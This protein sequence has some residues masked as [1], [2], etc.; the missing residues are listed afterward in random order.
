MLCNVKKLTYVEYA[1]IKVSSTKN[2]ILFSTLTRILNR[3]LGSEF[4]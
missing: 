1:H 3:V 2:K 4:E